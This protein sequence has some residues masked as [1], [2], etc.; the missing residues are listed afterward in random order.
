MVA[1]SSAGG[2][3]TSASF[4]SASPRLFSAVAMAPSMLSLTDC[5]ISGAKGPSLRASML[6]TGFPWSGASG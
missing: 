4:S 3:A 2:G 1:R 5:Y 6:D